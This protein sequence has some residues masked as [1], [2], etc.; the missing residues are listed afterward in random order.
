MKKRT[1]VTILTLLMTTALFVSGC[2]KA[3][4]PVGETKE[5]V[6]EENTDTTVA[7]VEEENKEEGPFLLWAK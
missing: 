2:K 1:F 4:T 3:E 6:T 7:E 5:P